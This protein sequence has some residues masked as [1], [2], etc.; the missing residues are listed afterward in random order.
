MER[1]IYNLFQ[2]EVEEGVE[3]GAKDR[4]A[5]EV[6]I[7]DSTGGTESSLWSL[8]DESEGES[9]LRPEKRIQERRRFKENEQSPPEEQGWGR[10]GD[11]TKN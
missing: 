3:N 5:M 7:E 2:N 10:V 4:S 8:G 9:E 11:M 6:G 1:L